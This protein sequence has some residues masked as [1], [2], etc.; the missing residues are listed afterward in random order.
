MADT[1][2]A[3]TDFTATSG[4]LQSASIATGGTAV[5]TGDVAVIA[6]VGN[7]RQLVITV[8]GTA[9]STLTFAQ[10]DEPPSETAGEGDSSALTI[11]NGLSYVV[12]VPAGRFVQDNGTVRATVGGTGPVEVTAYTIPRSV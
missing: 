5:S 3:L 6:A 8:H 9:A 1:A 4:V 12:M 2:V 10:G 11:G 7:T